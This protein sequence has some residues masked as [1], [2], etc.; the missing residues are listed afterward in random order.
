MASVSVF[1]SHILLNSISKSL[2]LDNFS[3]N[4]AEVSLSD[5]TAMSMSMHLLSFLSS[6]TMSGLLA[7]ISLKCVHRHIPKYCDL[8]VT[9]VGWC[10]YYFSV[11]R[12]HNLCRSCDECMLLSCYADKFTLFSLIPG[13]PRQCYQSTI[14][15]RRLLVMRMRWVLYKESLVTSC[16]TQVPLMW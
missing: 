4:F 7:F 3:M 12:F 6:T 16:G 2:C 13:T 9:V 5:G 14:I 8:A 10:L 1:K 11:A 15:N